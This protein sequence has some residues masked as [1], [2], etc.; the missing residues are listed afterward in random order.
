MKSI[1]TA[2]PPIVDKE[3]KI[4]LLGTMPGEQSLKLQ[5]YYGHNGN[6]FWKLIFALFDCTITNDYEIKKQILLNNKIAVWDVLQFCERTGS[7][8]HNI[9]N[10][11]PNDFATFYSNY[12][13]IR[14][15]FFTSGKAEVFYDSY[16]KRNALITYHNLPSPSRANT[17]KSFDE[18]L[19]NWRVIIK[20]L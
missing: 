10:E 15:V 2:F 5:Q 9:K 16:I 8:D 19:Q 1:K 20:Y 4:L 11:V 6:Q 12:P 3:S 7:A 18:K 14:N 17:W 13:G